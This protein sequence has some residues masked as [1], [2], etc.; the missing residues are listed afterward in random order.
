ME[1]YLHGHVRAES[2]TTRNAGTVGG[3]VR[4]KRRVVPAAT[5]I[6]L[7]C[8]PKAAEDPRVCSMPARTTIG[9]GGL[10][11]PA[12]PPHLPPQVPIVC[13]MW[14]VHQPTTFQLPQSAQ[15]R[16]V[17]H[18][19][20]PRIVLH[21]VDEKARRRH[22]CNGIRTRTLGFNTGDCL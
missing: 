22:F 10:L 20:H 7:C 13:A 14:S 19:E 21:C 12:P 1:L 15:G 11:F 3:A 16:G 17:P 5:P 4:T 8:C 18:K 2:L 6:A 9:C